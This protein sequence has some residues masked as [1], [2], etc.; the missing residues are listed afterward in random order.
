MAY[1]HLALCIV[2]PPALTSIAALFEA[3]PAPLPPLPC[4]AR[5]FSAIL[6]YTPL[7]TTD[8][9]YCCLCTNGEI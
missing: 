4:H 1:T 2:L 7:M 9:L 6:L 8:V 5:A 3:V